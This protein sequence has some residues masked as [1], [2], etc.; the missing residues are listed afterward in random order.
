MVLVNP[1][2]QQRVEHYGVPV[3]DARV[4]VL[5]VHGRTIGPEYMCENVVKRLALNDVAFVAPAAADKAWYPKSFLEPIE[6]NQPGIDH[7][8]E[9]L[10]HVVNEL[11]DS[12]VD[13]QRIVWCGFSQGAC[14]VSQY[15]S[16]H[17]RAWGGLISL[18]G[19]L[20]GPRGTSW[21]INGDFDGMPMYISTS[22]IDPL[23]PTFRIEE[24][25]QIF[26]NAGAVVEVDLIIGRPHEISDA[27]I[28]RARSLLLAV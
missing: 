11:L 25:A 10:D 28:A 22:D 20:I 8:I 26:G 2:M 27:E 1:H 13:A 17:P 7:T 6:D 23:G 16:L 4:V 18:T 24:T 9:L 19:G 3:R 12:G 5:L 14:A 21:E 15:V